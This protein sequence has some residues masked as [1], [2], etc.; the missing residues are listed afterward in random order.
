M[1]YAMSQVKGQEKMALGCT[2]GGSDWISDFFF[3]L[4]QWSDIGISYPGRWLESLSLEVIKRRLDMTLE[5][6]KGSLDTTLGVGVV[7]VVLGR[8]L[9]KIILKGFFQHR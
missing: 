6:F 9:D 8:W 4:K 3:S 1:S 7:M 2:Q 5:V